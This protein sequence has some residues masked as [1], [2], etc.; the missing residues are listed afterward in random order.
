MDLINSAIALHSLKSSHQP[1]LQ[2]QL[3]SVCFPLM[4]LLKV[5]YAAKQTEQRVP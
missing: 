4:P 1:Q 5:Q 2:K 3:I